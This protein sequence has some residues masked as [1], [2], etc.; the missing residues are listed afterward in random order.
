MVG[1][2]AP[3]TCCCALDPAHGCV[4]LH[5]AAPSVLHVFAQSCTAVCEGSCTVL[6]CAFARSVLRASACICPLLHTPAPSFAVSPA[7]SRILLHASTPSSLRTLLPT[8]A[9]PNLPPPSPSPSPRCRQKEVGGLHPPAARSPP[10]WGRSTWAQPP[11]RA[12]S[13]CCCQQNFPTAALATR[14]RGAAE[15]PPR[16]ALPVWGGGVSCPCKTVPRG[17]H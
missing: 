8:F 1:L 7:R 2:G 10:L 16:S 14:G 4:F 11:A 12:R 17:W 13:F 15:E 3:W 6:P 5:A 9:H